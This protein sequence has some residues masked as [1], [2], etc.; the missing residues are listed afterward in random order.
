MQSSSLI[1]RA[2]AL[3]CALGASTLPAM[4]Q[5]HD[6]SAVPAAVANKQK[7]EIKKGDPQRWHR[8][9]NTQ[10]ARLEIQKKEIAAAYAE[11]KNSCH[12]RSS[13][14]RARCL[15]DARATYQH[16]LANAQTLVAE[17]PTSQVIERRGAD[18]TVPPEAQVGGSQAGATESGGQPVTPQSATSS[19][20]ASESGASQSGSQT[21]PETPRSDTSQQHY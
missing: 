16:D 19:S 21:Q 20:G 9:D 18:V 6:D 7:A 13:S 17:A 8:G 4:A 3:A 1:L 12:K 2:A 5:T 11:A 14:Q 10:Q 15:K